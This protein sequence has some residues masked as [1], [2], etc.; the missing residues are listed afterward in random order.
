V[1]QHLLEQGYCIVAR[2]LRLGYLELDLVA[3]KQRVIAIVE[4]RTRGCGAWTT[5]LGSLT[6]TKRQRIRRAGKLLWQ[7]RYRSDTS[8]DRLRFDAASVQ[9]DAQGVASVEYVIAAF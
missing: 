6:E 9:F 2:N 4:V 1:A 5:A 8:V 3:R 7:R